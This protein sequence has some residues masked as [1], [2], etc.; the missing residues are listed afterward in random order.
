MSLKFFSTS[1]N[2]IMHFSFLPVV[3]YSKS[4][5][6]LT[7]LS[8]H[9]VIKCTDGSNNS[10][11]LSEQNIFAR[12]STPTPPIY[13]LRRKSCDFDQTFYAI[14]NSLPSLTARQS[15]STFKFLYLTVHICAK[16]KTFYITS[17]YLTSNLVIVCHS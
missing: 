8:S 3:L 12:L 7:G 17:L 5:S 4:V 2:I 14:F 11:F 6:S 15:V 9:V 10:F 13:L 1:K 16:I